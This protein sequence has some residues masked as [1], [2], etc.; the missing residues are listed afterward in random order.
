MN[1]RARLR[2]FAEGEPEATAAVREEAGELDPIP[3]RLPDLNKPP[4]ARGSWEQA[5][6]TN[7]AITERIKRELGTQT[8]PWKK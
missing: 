3:A 2:R 1:L 6:L 4:A 5:A 8:P 7:V